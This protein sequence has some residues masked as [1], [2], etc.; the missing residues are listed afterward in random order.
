MRSMFRMVMGLSLFTMAIANR[1]EAGFSYQVATFNGAVAQNTFNLGDT[2]T[3]RLF[4]VD[5]AGP[6]VNFATQNVRSF[7]AQLFASTTDLD[8]ASSATFN[9]SFNAGN[10]QS[11]SFFTGRNLTASAVSS[12]FAVSGSQ[13]QLAEFTYV[14][15]VLGQ[16]NISF[17]NPSNNSLEHLT[18]G[19]TGPEISSNPGAFIGATV[20]AVPEPTS[21]ALLGFVAAGYGLRRLRRKR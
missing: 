21:L 10:F 8:P 20:T 18:F 1:V 9:P 3:V 19:S 5:T 12:G 14:A 13:L 2:V 15:S 11:G 16:T 4:A 6:N 7:S 17:G